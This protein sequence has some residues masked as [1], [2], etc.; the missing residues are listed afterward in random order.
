VRRV[1]HLEP[2]QAH[3]GP[4][5]LRRSTIGAAG[6]LLE[7]CVAQH[8]LASV[9]HCGDARGGVDDRSDVLDPPRRRIAH[10]RDLAKVNAHA[11]PQPAV[12]HPAVVGVAQLLRGARVVE[13]RLGPVGLEQGHLDIAAPGQR[14][15][16]A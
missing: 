15:G 11:H 2:A 14:V 3:Q 6:K 1:G 16:R 10:E 9:G 7:G 13:Q 12:Q 5:L 8:D 4:S